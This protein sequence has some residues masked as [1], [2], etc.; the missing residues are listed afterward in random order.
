MSNAKEYVIFDSNK[1]EFFNIKN[2]SE[3]CRLKKISEREMRSVSKKRQWQHKGFYCKEKNDN[4]D[5]LEIYKKRSE[6]I[7]PKNKIFKD[8]QQRYNQSDEFVFLKNNIQEVYNEYLEQKMT[9][10][11]LSDKYKSNPDSISKIFKDNGLK[12]YKRYIPRCG[13]E[14]HSRLKFNEFQKEFIDN[15]EKYFQ[16]FHYEK[17]LSLIEIANKTELSYQTILDNCKKYNLEINSQNESY[18]HKKILKLLDEIGV[19][20]KSN[21]RTII[22][23][24]ELDIVIQDSNIAIEINGLYHHSEEHINKSYHLDKLNAAKDK[25]YTLL[26]FWD[27]EVLQ[28]PDIVMGIIKS[29]LNLNTKI[30]ARKC[31]IKEISATIANSF[32]DKNHIQGKRSCN[33]NYGLYYNDVLV[34]VMSFQKH[35]I[36]QY[37]LIR[38]ASLIGFTVVGG[39]SKLIKRFIK[40]KNV[41]SILTFCD[42][43]L[44]NGNSYIDFGFDKLYDTKINYHYWK[45]DKLESRIKYQKHKLEKILQ[46]F[47]ST[48]S[49][50]DNMKQ[51]GFRRVWDCGSI[52]LVWNNN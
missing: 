39:F 15:F 37:E 47:D 50:A 35:K 52:K 36:Y 5:L 25:K 32:I 44:F 45:H 21:V 8:K 26:H 43:R 2:L 42:K 9:L 16:E 19:K 27:I 3:F 7:K 11:Q 4:T 51:N 40:D 10:S 1:N 28:K 38:S 12:I 41:N 33:I 17:K 20:T 14:H 30:F 13:N 46:F 48:K 6:Y 31:I 24:K 49:E 34:M 18:P 29:K 22:S 23:P